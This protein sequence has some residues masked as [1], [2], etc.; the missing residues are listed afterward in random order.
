MPKPVQTKEVDQYGLPSHS[1]G[2]RRRELKQ[3][4]LCPLMAGV[5]GVPI[6]LNSVVR[7]WF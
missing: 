3:A 2:R 6:P 4:D 7:L 1:Y 5:L